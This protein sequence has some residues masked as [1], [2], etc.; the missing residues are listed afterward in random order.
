MSKLDVSR[1]K[2]LQVGSAAFTLPLAAAVP[3][4]AQSSPNPMGVDFHIELPSPPAHIPNRKL[5][6]RQRGTTVIPVDPPTDGVSDCSAVI[7]AAI[8]ALPEDGGTVLIKY[9]RTGGINESVYMMNLMANQQPTGKKA[10]YAL[11][12]RSNVLLQLEPGVQLQ[13]MANNVPRAYMFLLQNVHDVEIA[14]GAILGERFNHTNS[15]KGTDEWGF[16]ISLSGSTAI[17]IRNIL[18]SNFEGDGITIA[19]GGS[20]LV[21]P[22]DIVLWKTRCIGNR[23]QGVSLTEGNGV[24]LWDSEFSWTHGTA[25]ADGLDIEGTVSNVFIDRCLFDT[26]QGNGVELNPGKTGQIRNINITN[27]VFTGNYSALYLSSGST[28]VMDTCTMYGNAMYQNRWKALH[29]NGSVTRNFKIGGI[30]PCDPRNNSFANNQ[31]QYTH[32]VMYPLT[33][34]QVKQG[35]FA[36]T[37]MEASTYVQSPESGNVFGWN[38]YPAVDDGTSQLSGPCGILGL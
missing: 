16:G 17:T 10:Y 19:Q 31:T 30:G 36:G 9:H 14:G 38:F 34:T 27:C 1:R 32:Q 20:P 7:Q 18:V 13:A 21:V 6:V 23:R 26:N 22:T 35:Y 24:Y 8:D 33:A 29:I 15:G 5:P 28:N 3:A 4:A 37:D 25:P 2:F 12:L 11:N